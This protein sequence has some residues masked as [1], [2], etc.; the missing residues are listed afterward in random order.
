M[1]QRFSNIISPPII[2]I[3]LTLWALY[4]RF[5]KLAGRE[6]WGDE[7]FQLRIMKGAFKPIWKSKTNRFL[8]N[9]HT[10]AS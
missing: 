2:S 5:N 6:L 7:I 1:L 9:S 8:F 4:L 3:T 10:S